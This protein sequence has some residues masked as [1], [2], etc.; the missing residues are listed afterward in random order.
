MPERSRPRMAGNS[1]GYHCLAS[2]LRTFQSMGLMLAAATRT[3]TSPGPATGSGA[4]S[5]FSLDGAP[6]SC[7]RTAF[8]NAPLRDLMIRRSDARV[9]PAGGSA[10]PWRQ[11]FVFRSSELGEGFGSGVATRAE[12]AGVF[13]GIA[14]D[15]AGAVEFGALGGE[16]FFA[17]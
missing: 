9:L 16:F 6:Y 10:A 5:Y 4:S 11:I 13:G 1:S 15:G 14:L 12:Q 17:G 7:K 2:P 8:M 3:R